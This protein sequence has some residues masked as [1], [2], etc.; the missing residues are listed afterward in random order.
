MS[1]GNIYVEQRGV[2]QFAVV[3]PGAARASAILPTQAEAIERAKEI[4]P[5]TRPDV[6]RVRH[7]SVGKPDQWR[8]G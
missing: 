2:R 5:N 3:K 6:E 4:S 1:K 8:R 7:T